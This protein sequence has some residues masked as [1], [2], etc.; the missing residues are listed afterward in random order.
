MD[1]E[2]PV[3]ETRAMCAGKSG[4]ESSPRGGTGSRE[5]LF[6]EKLLGAGRGK[7]VAADE[8]LLLAGETFEPLFREPPIG[9]IPE[10]LDPH[11]SVHGCVAEYEEKLEELDR[12]KAFE[13]NRWMKERIG[14]KWCVAGK[15]YELRAEQAE[16]GG[17]EKFWLR[18]IESP[19]EYGKL[20]FEQDERDETAVRSRQR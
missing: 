12:W 2:R 3:A 1:S 5:R 18:L 10:Y 6:F 16:G 8:I 9:P 15:A 11:W 20:A 17:S 19:T 7:P 14:T 13:L 4:A